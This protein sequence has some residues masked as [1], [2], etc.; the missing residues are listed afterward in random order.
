MVYCNRFYTAIVFIFIVMG[1]SLGYGG[2]A[3]PN[4]LTVYTSVD[5]DY[6]EPVISEFIDRNPEMEVQAVY[7][8]ELT[9]TTGLFNRILHEKHNPQCDVFWNSEMM[10]TVQLKKEGLLEAY[11]SPSAK[12]IPIRFK[13]P[14]GY[15][16]GFSA[17]ARVMIINT[18]LVP[19]SETPAS[20]PALQ[21]PKYRGK[22]AMAIPEFGTTVSHMAAL[23]T[24]WGK[25]RF[26]LIFSEIKKNGIK[27]LPGNATVRDEVAAGNLA[28]GLTDTDDA[29]VALAEEKPVRMEFLSQDKHGTLMIPNTV[30]LIKD[31]PNPENGKKFIDFLLSHEIEQKL[32]ESR[33]K[34]IP[35]RS[36]VPRPDM[37]PNLDDIEVMDVDYDQIVENLNECLETLRLFIPQ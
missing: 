3:K 26:Q 2:C 31:S 6:S 30:C 10:R 32:A 13:D 21:L 22:I 8:S 17:R 19:E 16:T 27:F 34:Q 5:Q 25:P 11:H 37:V 23:Y 1:L 35:V 29:F 20:V 15:W 28:Y 14:E 36:A 18:D 24:V 33:A 12:D 9:K 4:A 7:D